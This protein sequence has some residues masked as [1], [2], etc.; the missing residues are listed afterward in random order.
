MSYTFINAVFWAVPIK[1]TSKIATPMV[2]YILRNND[3]DTCTLYSRKEA[4]DL[5][6]EFGADNVDSKSRINDDGE[7]CFYLK[8][9]DKSMKI[10]QFLINHTQ[11]RCLYTEKYLEEINKIL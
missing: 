10:N 1:E 9:K 11:I 6:E 5:I 2:G 3:E 8:L 7:V 4:Y